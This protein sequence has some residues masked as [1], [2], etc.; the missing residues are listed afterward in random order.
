MIEYY[1]QKAL[2]ASDRLAFEDVFAN[3]GVKGKLKSLVPDHYT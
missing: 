1:E 2:D 3:F